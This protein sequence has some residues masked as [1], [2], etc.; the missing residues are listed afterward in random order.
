M[1]KASMK[2][3]SHSKD[4]AFGILPIRSH[5][6]HRK[7]WK[8]LGLPVKRPFYRPSRTCHGQWTYSVV[9]VI[10][11]DNPHIER[12]LASLLCQTLDFRTHIQVVLVD[13]GTDE[14]SG[15]TCR[16]WAARYPDNITYL[17]HAN[18]SL[19]SARNAGIAHATGDW[20]TF[21]APQDLL[22]TDYFLN[23]DKALSAEAKADNLYLL[24]C[25]RV[26]FDENDFT[27]T[28]T[29]P[30]RYRFQYGRRRVVFDD[31]CD[32]IVVSVTAVLFNR[33]TLLKTG[34][35]FADICAGADE[36]YFVSRYLLS[37]ET[38]EVLFLP[39]ARYWRCSPANE[40]LALAID[41][42]NPDSYSTLLQEGYLDLQKKACEDRPDTPLWLQ[43]TIVYGLAWHFK[44][45]LED[46]R[47]A[48]L[49]PAELRA[50]YI[51]LLHTILNRID[52]KILATFELAEVTDLHRLAMLAMAGHTAER[53]SKVALIAFDK[54]QEAV[55]LSYYYVGPQPE[56]RV[57]VGAESVSP[58]AAKTRIHRFVFNTLV[59]E[60][61]GWFPWQGNGL[62]TVFLNG[63]W[64]E[65]D[66]EQ[67]SKHSVTS[68]FTAS[69][70]P[71]HF[72]A[73]LKM[74][75]FLLQL[76]FLSRRFKNG[77]VLIDRDIHADDNAEHLYRY[78]RAHHPQ[79]NAWFALRK[80][81]H[82]W[83]RLKQEGFRLLAFGSLSHKLALLHAEQFISSQ[84][85]MSLINCLPMHVYKDLIHWKFTYLR[86]GV[87]ISD[88]SYW[89]N[90]VPLRN[91]VASVQKEYDSICLD[92][93]PYRFTTREVA[94]TG[95]PRHDRLIRK[96]AINKPDKTILIMPTWR[97]TLVAQT[98]DRQGELSRNPE[99]IHTNFFK[100]WFA[101]LNSLE[102][103][104]LTT[105]FGYKIAFF[106]HPYLRPYNAEF[107]TEHVQIINPTEL[108]SVQDLLLNT[109][110]LITDYSSIALEMAYLQRSILYYQFDE[111]FVFGGGHTIEKGFFDYRRDGFGPV[112]T[113][114]A[115]LLQELEAVL[116]NHGQAFEPYC[117]R[118]QD[119]FA[120]RDGRCCERVFDLIVNADESTDYNTLRHSRVCGNDGGLLRVSCSF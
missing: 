6:R 79:I 34:L 114:Q 14:D 35:A 80:T 115:E 101:L 111:D 43:R 25:N 23:A 89:L 59:R 107:R 50:G 53:V 10:S 90:T 47:E 67:R 91:L 63:E 58:T 97:S 56:P 16:D 57:R 61:I 62:L 66:L 27:I 4:I 41:W 52:S 105:Q 60:Y 2:S 46:H 5:S 76:P 103:F 104:Q 44:R 48:Y 64:I 84:G 109:S 94:L 87:A 65:Q 95:L 74:K 55:C 108:R 17:P 72:P 15:Q 21:I 116:S 102:L 100:T 70:N 28:D 78:I 1:V 69:V 106:P 18:A 86:H 22:A 19:A 112:C 73:T 51:E 113:S 30:L 31:T 20:L 81:S 36:F 42:A 24:A 39:E 99:F 71:K 82:D 12:M 32:D 92:E 11:E 110:V 88:Q 54:T 119:F 93:T 37:A 26:T 68:R 3:L 77:W 7:A 49:I 83:E 13:A 8:W 9:S 33:R 29:D 117:Q 98:R 85:S 40:A 120:F 118:M 45:L 38:P 75:R 96:K